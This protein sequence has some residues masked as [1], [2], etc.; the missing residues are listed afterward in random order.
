[1]KSAFLPLLLLAAALLPAPPVP[2][3]DPLPASALPVGR[4]V[5]KTN[6][7]VSWWQHEWILKGSDVRFMAE[8]QVLAKVTVEFPAN[9]A[10]QFFRL[11]PRGTLHVG[12]GESVSGFSDSQVQWETNL[13]LEIR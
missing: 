6:V 13:V 8:T 5:V 3:P 7:A 12:A 1:M 2:S 10:G 9:E 11:Q 4:I